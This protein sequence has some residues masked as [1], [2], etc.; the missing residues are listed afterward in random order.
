[1][2]NSAVG[3]VIVLIAL[4]VVAAIH[5][6]SN[7]KPITNFEECIAAGNPAMESYPRQCRDPI[8]DRTFVEE[9]EDAW[10]LDAI[11]LMQHRTEGWLACFGCSTATDGQAI[12]IDPV[13]EMVNM[14]ET[15]ERHCNN[16]FEVVGSSG[17]LNTGG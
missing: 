17:T 11:G 5:Y 8:S 1:M 16:D 13:Q 12:C 4:A 7:T 15:E 10:R 3:I 2:K 6:S 9:I 14:E